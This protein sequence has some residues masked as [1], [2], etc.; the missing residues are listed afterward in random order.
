MTIKPYHIYKFDKSEFI[1][2]FQKVQIPI[3]ILSKKDFLHK[4]FKDDLYTYEQVIKKLK[5]LERVYYNYSNIQHRDFGEKLAKQYEN[6]ILN[7]MPIELKEHAEVFNINLNRD[8]YCKSRSYSNIKTL[9]IVRH[10][11]RNSIDINNTTLQ[12]LVTKYYK[13]NEDFFIKLVASELSFT[14][15]YEIFDKAWIQLANI[16]SIKNHKQIVEL[17]N[18]INRNRIYDDIKLSKNTIKTVIDLV[19]NNTIWMDSSASKTLTSMLEHIDMTYEQKK[20]LIF[21]KANK[22]TSIIAGKV[23]LDSYNLPFQDTLTEED[24]YTLINDIIFI[25]NNS[26]KIKWA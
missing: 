15:D 25:G 16:L 20:Q 14:H 11:D 24:Y 23:T 7:F 19:C 9:N 12:A 4:Y 8:H 2:K 1:K 18:G 22:C 26:I 21:A 5:I 6:A 17:L 10:L 3:R 13:G